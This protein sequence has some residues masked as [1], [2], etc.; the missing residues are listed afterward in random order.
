MYVQDT[1]KENGHHS[2][3]AKSQSELWFPYDDLRVRAIGDRGEE[4]E[5]TIVA[6]IFE[7]L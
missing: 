7:R 3:T 6:G 4:M 1:G 2:A 5:G